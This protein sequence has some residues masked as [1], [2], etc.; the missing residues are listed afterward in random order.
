LV[1]Y[2]QLSRKLQ[3]INRAGGKVTSVTEA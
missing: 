1:S 3:Q 2:E